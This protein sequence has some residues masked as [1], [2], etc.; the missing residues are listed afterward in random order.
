MADEYPLVMAGPGGDY[1]WPGQG[2]CDVISASEAHQNAMAAEARRVRSA[3]Q[4]PAARPIYPPVLRPKRRLSGVLEP[5][6]HNHATIRSA[7]CYGC[8]M[9]AVLMIG[10]CVAFVYFL[11]R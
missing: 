9:T 2:M 7:F 6:P 10:L 1:Y 5:L 3:Y 4:S 8:V 11:R